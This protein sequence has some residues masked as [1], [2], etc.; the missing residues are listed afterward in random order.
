MCESITVAA[1]GM[2]EL[3]LYGVFC[4]CQTLGGGMCCGQ[5]LFCGSIIPGCICGG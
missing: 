2:Y 5:V 3:F 4:C 1:Y